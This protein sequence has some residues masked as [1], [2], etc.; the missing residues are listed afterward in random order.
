GQAQLHHLGE[1]GPLPAEEVLLVAI[2]LAEHVDVLDHRVLL[3]AVTVGPSWHRG[4]PVSEAVPHRDQEVRPASSSL[5]RRSRVRRM[6][7]RGNCSKV[8]PPVTTLS[9][10]VATKSGHG[11]SSVHVS[12]TSVPPVAVPPSLRAASSAGSK[13]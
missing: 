4:R 6:L 12:V 13:R 7:V 9:K 5:L 10:A 3:G 2:A 1:V 11:R 8:R